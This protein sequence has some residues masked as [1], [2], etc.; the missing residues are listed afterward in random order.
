MSSCL[1][2][3]YT[4]GNI[5]SIFLFFLAWTF[6]YPFAVSFLWNNKLILRKKNPNK[7]FSQL[8]GKPDRMEQQAPVCC[9][10]I[11]R[12][13]II[14]H[15]SAVTTVRITIPLGR[16]IHLVKDIWKVTF[17]RYLSSV[18]PAARPF[19]PQWRH[20]LPKCQCS[21]WLL[22]VL[23]FCTALLYKS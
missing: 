5:L 17:Q 15:R 7:P 13:I 18:T 19:A 2:L 16:I 23:W 10:A 20:L 6:V 14:Y 4:G 1:S 21:V 11:A 12:V 22:P 9:G 8:N 3:H